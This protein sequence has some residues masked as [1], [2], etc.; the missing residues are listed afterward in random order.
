MICRR[1]VYTSWRGARTALRPQSV[2]H[3]SPYFKLTVHLSP[4]KLRYIISSGYLAY[5]R[6][7]TS[8]D[9]FGISLKL[10]ILLLL[11]SIANFQQLCITAYRTLFECTI[12]ALNR[13][14]IQ[15]LPVFGGL[16]YELDVDVD[17]N[18]PPRRA[19][20]RRSKPQINISI[21]SISRFK[22]TVKEH[23][24]NTPAG[25]FSYFPV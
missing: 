15:S 9:L 23:S 3:S 8:C 14:Q 21:S 4:I 1:V 13:S 5:I 10:L 17:E 20:G 11:L 18:W 12:P 22:E 25:F 24:H 2:G 6:Y 19:F 16:P 7:Y